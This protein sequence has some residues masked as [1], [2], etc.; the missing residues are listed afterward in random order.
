MIEQSTNQTK[1]G[2]LFA[3][4]AYVMW[5]LAPLYFKA[6][7]DVPPPEILMHRVVWSIVLLAVL[8]LGLRHISKVKIAFSSIKVLSVLLIASVLLATNWLVYIW[9]VNNNFML[10]A[11]LGYYI[12]P[13]INVF[14][15]RLFLGER[16]RVLQKIAV[17][18]AVIGVSLMIIN[19]GKIPYISL[20]LAFSFSI[21]GLLRKRINIDSLPGLFVE[22]LMML[23]AAII[24]WLWFAQVS[25]DFEALNTTTLILLLCA[26]VMTTAPLL[27]F[28]AAAKRIRYSTLGFFQYIGPSIMFALA[29]FYYQEPLSQTRL[30]MFIFV[31]SALI[32]YTYD[33]V[34]AFNKERKLRKQK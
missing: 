24:Y 14:L 33:S 10:E 9:A 32:I 16:L 5:G 31:W 7:N 28:T 2:M 18:V 21:Y 29:T 30:I 13:L 6:L 15:A 22:T 34:I 1:A 11:S 25:T 12:N 17:L 19:Y 3:V 26:G 27:C 23:P 4:A 8:V 20:T